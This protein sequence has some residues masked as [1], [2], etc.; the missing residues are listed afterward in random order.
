MSIKLNLIFLAE[1]LVFEMG[2][3]EIDQRKTADLSFLFEIRNFRESCCVLCSKQAMSHYLVQQSRAAEDELKRCR[4]WPRRDTIMTARE[5]SPLTGPATGAHERISL[6]GAVMVFFAVVV[7]F[8]L[9]SF[10]A[11]SLFPRGVKGRASTQEVIELSEVRIFE[12]EVLPSLPPG[13]CI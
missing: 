5:T 7:V 2:R 9:A 12:D 13:A 10:S 1:S 4:V 3:I 8:G 6:R 11:K